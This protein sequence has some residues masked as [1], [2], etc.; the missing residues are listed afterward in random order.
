MIVR[1][2][3][4]RPENVSDPNARARIRTWSQIEEYVHLD[5]GGIY[6]VQAVEISNIFG[7]KLYLDFDLDRGFPSPF[8]A[9]LFENIDSKLHP[10]WHLNYE[11]NVGVGYGQRISFKEWA[12][13]DV[14]FE[15][16]IS[17]EEYAFNTYKKY[18]IIL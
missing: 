8:P 18:R 3:Y 2:K 10:L 16:L 11:A 12:F 17:R 4:I 6:A 1:C 13:S 9:D 5:E 14:F 15:K 7:V